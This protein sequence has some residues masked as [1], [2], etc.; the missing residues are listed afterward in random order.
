MHLHVKYHKNCKTIVVFQ[1]RNMLV[2][3]AYQIIISDIRF[4]S[5]DLVS[6]T[7]PTFAHSLSLKMTVDLSLRSDTG[8]TNQS[9][10]SSMAS[11]IIHPC[12]LNQ[13]IHIPGKKK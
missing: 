12:E 9:P 6:L 7:Q 13:Y 11:S 3:I 2:N 5:G 8:S 4:A 10:V 1:S